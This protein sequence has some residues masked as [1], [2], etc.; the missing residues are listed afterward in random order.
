MEWSKFNFPLLQ[1]SKHIADAKNKF[2][3]TFLVLG[4]MATNISFKKNIFEITV[5]E[6]GHM[7]LYLKLRWL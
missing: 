1:S 6:G 4:F 5:I 2:L 3:D 7:V